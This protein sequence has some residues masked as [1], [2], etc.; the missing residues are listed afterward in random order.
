MNWPF[1]T[2]LCSLFKKLAEDTW[3]RLHLGNKYQCSQ[4]ETTITDLNLLEIIRARPAGL[5]AFKTKPRYE[6]YV[7]F[8]WEWWIRG[9]NR[10]WRRYVVQARVLDL[11]NNR[12]SQIRHRVNGR[13][14]IDILNGFARYHQAIPLYCF[15]NW[16]SSTVARAAWN[17][18]YN[19]DEKQLGCT[20]APLDV[21]RTIHTKYHPKTFSAAHQ[22]R[23][24]LPWSCIVCCPMLLRPNDVVDP[25]DWRPME[26][27]QLP[28]YL[29]VEPRDD[30]DDGSIVDLPDDFYNPEL[31]AYPK[32]IL[33]IDPT[34]EV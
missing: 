18:N 21:V 5:R 3:D 19:Y 13:F 1:D 14:Q 29:N 30:V 15:Y 2:R 24:V 34:A 10:R 28:P 12:Y 31:G 22:S 7:G 17:C 33:V 9:T 27:E 26:V 4:G 11:R 8:D 6:P 16:V 23:R 25:S 20:L 32:R